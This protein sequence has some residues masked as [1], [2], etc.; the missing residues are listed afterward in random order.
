M[1]RCVRGLLAPESEMVIFMTNQEMKEC[2][3]SLCAWHKARVEECRRFID[4]E[5]ADITFDIDGEKCVIPAHS[6]EAKLM[7]LGAETALF[8]FEKFPVTLNVKDDEDDDDEE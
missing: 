6:H 3:V 4:K 1:A 7:R 2:I 5:D 8:M